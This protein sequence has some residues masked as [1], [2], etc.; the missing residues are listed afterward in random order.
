M[1][2]M[3]MMRSDAVR[4]AAIVNLRN[5]S[6]CTPLMAPI[7]KRALYL[8]INVNLDRR[9]RRVERVHA[10]AVLHN[11]HK[12]PA[13]RT[14]FYKAELRYKA[15]GAYRKGRSQ[16][17][18]KAPKTDP[19]PRSTSA[20]F[21]S[22]SGAGQSSGMFLGGASGYA[23]DGGASA[24]GGYGSG[25]G[26]GD[27]DGEGGGA[28]SWHEVPGV[29][30]PGAQLKLDKRPHEK[31]AGSMLQWMNQQFPPEQPRRLEGW[32]RLTV[33][34]DPYKIPGGG[35]PSSPLGGADSPGFLPH[36]DDSSSTL[37]PYGAAAER[38]PNGKLKRSMCR[39]VN[40]IWGVVPGEGAGVPGTGGLRKGN[41]RWG[42]VV[43][44][45]VTT[46][47]KMHLTPGSDELL[48]ARRP[49]STA[50][51]LNKAAEQVAAAAAADHLGITGGHNPRP[52]TSME[53]PTRPWQPL[54][55]PRG[56]LGTTPSFVSVPDATLR[57]LSPTPGEQPPPLTI[58][59]GSRGASRG[60]S[61][62]GSGGGQRRASTARAGA[63]A[64]TARGSG[65]R[66]DHQHVVGMP[67][68]F[69][70]SASVAGGAGGGAGGGGTIA[71]SARGSRGRGERG[72]GAP[73]SIIVT[74]PGKKESRGCLGRSDG[75]GFLTPEPT[76]RPRPGT[77]RPGTGAGV[78]AETRNPRLS[79]G[80]GGSRVASARVGTASGGGGRRPYTT[81]GGARGG[82]GGAAKAAGNEGKEDRGD[83]LG[84]ERFLESFDKKPPRAAAAGGPFAKSGHVP[85]PKPPPSASAGGGRLESRGGGGGGSGSGGGMDGIGDAAAAAVAGDKPGVGFAAEWNWAGGGGGGGGDGGAGAG[86]GSGSGNGG[87]GGGSFTTE[88]GA[89][90]EDRRMALQVVLEQRGSSRHRI[91]F[92]DKPENIFK[93][94][95]G[96]SLRFM[97]WKKVPG[98]RVH[99]D[100]PSYQLPNGLRGHFYDRG[101]EFIDEATA[102]AATPPN[103]PMTLKGL[104]QCELP[105]R[106]VLVELSTPRDDGEIA[107]IRPTPR[108]PPDP[109]RHTLDVAQPPR[110]FGDLRQHLPLVETV[111]ETVHREEKDEQRHKIEDKP[112]WDINKSVFAPRRRESDGKDYYNHA[113]VKNQ[114][115]ESDW[116]RLT[117]KERFVGFV[118]REAKKAAVADGKPTPQPGDE[119]KE[120]KDCLKKNFQA[121]ARSF[122]YY[123]LLGT[124][125]IFSMQLNEYSD[126]IDECRIPDHD[127]EHCK[128]SHCDT[129]FITANYEENDDK[130]NDDNA[131]MRF[132]FLEI[133][134]RMAVMKFGEGQSETWDLSDNINRLISELILPSMPP[135]AVQDEDE[136][137]RK[138][139]YCE[140]MDILYDGHLELLKALYSRYRLPPREGGVRAKRMKLDDWML[141][142]EDVK[143]VDDFFTIRDLKCCFVFARMTAIDEY[144]IRMNEYITFVDFLDALGRVAELVNLPVQRELERLG[145]AN[146]LTYHEVVIV[147][148]DDHRGP[149]RESTSF[150]K[151]KTRRLNLKTEMLLELIFRRLDQDKNASSDKAAEGHDAS[152]NAAKLLKRLKAIDK[153]LGP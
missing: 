34:T 70:S 146:V 109:D 121:L 81:S 49:G 139:L 105:P 142:F 108:L 74:A 113:K 152:F 19:L 7:A 25:G 131:L 51:R 102:A 110:F 42:P 3:T 148:G 136:Y 88:G 26:E 69:C 138:R 59:E 71:R 133:V 128:R 149:W 6:S 94:K 37:H 57:R 122:I 125:D 116:K 33:P 120:C 132:E 107:A 134:V 20:E 30:E 5:L 123:S 50:R 64:S 58:I 66:T 46:D 75:G 48:T 87:G 61:G 129:L 112:P 53:R 52:S 45:Y 124:G 32:Q 40:K 38:N 83:R 17:P 95:S 97:A 104:L 54:A 84:E 101:S 47:A 8:L 44:E 41:L 24:D 145:H 9:R 151:P 86:N 56:G 100:L 137:R 91:T 85:P 12:E 65:N 126:F 78:R 93:V 115:F 68:T 1:L 153:N 16:D 23:S 127:S 13:N 147:D 31:M 92:E 130:N 4:E 35:R 111:V 67:H 55:V 27:G 72:A 15:L 73:V 18:P 77:G 10:A 143:L 150:E 29:L 14:R 96:K 2:P 22:L 21:S 11:I 89:S 98:S 39:P 118:E 90:A 79:A 82:G 63:R 119:L 28:G 62:G 144:A 103:Q 36:I 106:T 114:Q 76:D 135:M 141:L 140:E 43:Q 60:G 99:D 80:G 117:G